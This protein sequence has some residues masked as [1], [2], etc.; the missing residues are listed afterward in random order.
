[1][2]KMCL[3]FHSMIVFCLMTTLP[4]S[5]GESVCDFILNEGKLRALGLYKSLDK[6]F[7]AS[8]W[9][10]ARDGNE[11]VENDFEFELKFSFDVA[12]DLTV[13]REGVPR[14]RADQ[15][16]YIRDNFAYNFNTTINC[17][18][19]RHVLNSNVCQD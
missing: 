9:L 15:K 16:F 5:Y 19:R 3:N 7:N 17:W 8:Y 12:L 14:V 1:M 11:T 18:L 6:D 4:D 13:S 10:F 2:T